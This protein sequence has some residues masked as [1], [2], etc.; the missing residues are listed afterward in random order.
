MLAKPFRKV[1]SKA[2]ASAGIVVKGG[3]RTMSLQLFNILI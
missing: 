2:T 1:F 3:T